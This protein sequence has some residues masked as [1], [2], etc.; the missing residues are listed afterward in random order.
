[1]ELPRI[2]Q[3]ECED[4]VLY[5]PAGRSCEGDADG[6]TPEPLDRWARHA[7]QCATLKFP[8]RLDRATRGLV[9][10]CKT[11]ASIAKANE[12]IRK[13]FWRKYY[14][15]RIPAAA[16]E[17]SDR[18]LG[19]Q[20]LFLRRSGTRAVVVRSGG[21]ACAQSGLLLRN[22]T[23]GSPDAHLLIELKTG[24]FHQ[25]RAMLAHFGFPLVGDRL[26]G[27]LANPDEFEL[28]HAL[29]IR[30]GGTM[31][32]ADLARSTLLPPHVLRRGW[33]PDIHDRLRELSIEPVRA[34]KLVQPPQA[35]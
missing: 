5:K 15:A 1:M 20:K 4:A 3:D 21:D 16:G 18:L 11:G 9:V 14:V 19:E 27:S 8:H 29:L 32:A 34:G 7:L 25:I 17:L 2:V 6:N 31:A 12:E 10:V 30:G 23:D 35:S 24:R 26:Y 33:H 22:A 28:E 13:R